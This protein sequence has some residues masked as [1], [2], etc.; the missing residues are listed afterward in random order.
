MLIRCWIRCSSELISENLNRKSSVSFDILD[1]FFLVV[2]EILNA[3][4]DRWLTADEMVVLFQNRHLF[5]VSQVTVP[6]PGLFLVQNPKFSD[7]HDWDNFP[8]G[9]R[10]RSL[11][12]R[13][14]TSFNY[15]LAQ[16]QAFHR[17]TIRNT[18]LWDFSRFALICIWLHYVILI[19]F[20]FS[21]LCMQVWGGWQRLYSLSIRTRL[22]L[23]PHMTFESV[24]P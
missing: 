17:R 11:I 13:G 7:D 5:P 3:S 16:S 21:F 8:N 1:L 24:Q 18:H 6:G 23:S 9:R 2:R 14:N 15:S 19:L 12:L 20:F 22:N 4:R 10:L